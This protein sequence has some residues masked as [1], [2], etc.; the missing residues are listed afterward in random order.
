MEQVRENRVE[1]IAP[2]GKR[3][4][5][6]GAL[7]ASHPYEEPAFDVFELAAF[8]SSLGL[9]RLG[10]LDHPETLREFTAR[11]ARSLPSTEWGVRAAGDPDATVRTV[12]VCG[13]SGDSYLDV[14]AALG[15]DVYVTADLR[16]HP[17]DEHLR[18][19]GPALVDVA[20]WASEY[21]VRAGE[22]GARRRVCRQSGV[23]KPGFDNSHRSMVFE[24]ALVQRSARY[25]C[26]NNSR[27]VLR[28]P[29]FASTADIG[30]TAG[31]IQR[32]RRTTGAIQAS[33][34]RRGGC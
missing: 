9:G 26:T 32:E 11:V 1:V 18:A 19:G 21:V 14:V 29:S 10:E 27:A 28:E 20:H 16:H 3:S 17:A 31:V 15:A 23:G 33:R 25:G 6:L 2:R 22:I 34:P 12:A 4:A 13:G 30:L 7:R 8:P 24:C 5:V